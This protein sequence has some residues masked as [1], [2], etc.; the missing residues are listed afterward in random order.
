MDFRQK[1][2]QRS[3]WRK[4]VKLLVKTLKDR[5]GFDFGVEA[6]HPVS[7]DQPDIFHPHVNLFW[8]QR[9]RSSAFMPVRLLRVLW[10]N[11][12]NPALIDQDALK[13]FLG[14]EE[15][16]QEE[17]LKTLNHYESWESLIKAKN[18]ELQKTKQRFGL[19]SIEVKV[20]HSLAIATREVV[21]HH[22]YETF[23][24]PGKIMHW[25][26]YIARPFPGFSS[27]QGCI[28]WYGKFPIMPPEVYVCPNCHQC[29]VIIDRHIL[30]SEYLEE[31]VE[32]INTT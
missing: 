30:H 6:T 21:V 7:E 31:Q 16:S 25:A 4:K 29:Y 27:W 15:H 23:K 14:F 20:L 10:L 24:K 18:D 12:L 22:H 28:R 32:R 5:F 8:V 26:K 11:I 9:G 3:E 13:L 2:I 17:L 1:F 19:T